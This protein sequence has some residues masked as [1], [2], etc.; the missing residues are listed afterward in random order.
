MNLEAIDLCLEESKDLLG[1]V[2]HAVVEAQAAAYVTG[3]AAAP[4]ADAACPARDSTR[5]SSA[6][7]GV[8]LRPSR[9]CKLGGGHQHRRSGRGQRGEGRFITGSHAGHRF[10]RQVTV[11]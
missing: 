9:W 3:T 8:R 11:L 4:P 2:Q 6:P 1:R 7:G 5:S 10:K